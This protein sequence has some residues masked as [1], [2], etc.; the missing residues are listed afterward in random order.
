[1]IVHAHRTHQ[2]HLCV[3]GENYGYCWPKSDGKT[4]VTFL[5]SANTGEGLLYRVAR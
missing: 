1:M 2:P 3:I 5:R 4:N